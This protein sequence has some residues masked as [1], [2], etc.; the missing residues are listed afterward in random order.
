[1]SIMT[2]FVTLA[3]GYYWAK[4]EEIEAIFSGVVSL[5]SFLI[6][7]PFAAIIT[8]ADGATTVEGTGLL[9]LDRLGAKECS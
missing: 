6:L 9:T 3:I 4:S 1:M 2:V 8:S 5:A 7:T